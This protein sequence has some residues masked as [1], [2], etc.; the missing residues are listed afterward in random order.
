MHE[1]KEIEG[2]ASGTHDVSSTCPLTHRLVPVTDR[3]VGKQLVYHAIQT[4]PDEADSTP[5]TSIMSDT[6]TLREETTA[7]Q[8]E[9]KAL[10][11]RLAALAA[12]PS[13]SDLQ[14]RIAELEAEKA[15]MLARLQ[16]LRKGNVK[17]V[18][19]EEKDELEKEGRKWTGIE[20][21]RKRIARDMWD[22]VRDSIAE[23]TDVGEVWVWQVPFLVGDPV[24]TLMPGE[25]GTGRLILEA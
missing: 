12:C 10:R 7:L 6:A 19:N 4:I 23:G 11:T 8:A 13:T 15:K 9:A 22:F 17:K 21:R 3:H 14:T 18:S 5:I 16:P 1:R 2:R 20:Q 24:L 25:L